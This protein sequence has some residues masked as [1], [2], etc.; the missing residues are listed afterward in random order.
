M[1]YLS[2]TQTVQVQAAGTH[3]GGCR[4]CG[5]FGLVRC[6]A[7]SGRGNVCLPGADGNPVMALLGLRWC[8]VAKAMADAPTL[9]LSLAGEM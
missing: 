7:P 6:H 4:Q 2:N 9:C 1:L 5:D 3:G 8:P